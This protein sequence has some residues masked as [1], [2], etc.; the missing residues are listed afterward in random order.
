MNSELSQFFSG[1]SDDDDV[2]DSRDVYKDGI[3]GPERW[4]DPV[5]GSLSDVSGP[6]HIPYALEWMIC[7]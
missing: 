5:Q 6:E 3:G 4:E 1:S 7:R 2:Y